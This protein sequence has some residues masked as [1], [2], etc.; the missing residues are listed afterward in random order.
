ME[1]SHRDIFLSNNLL[2]KGLFWTA[3]GQYTT[4]IEIAQKN[5]VGHFSMLR[6]EKRQDV[7][8]LCFTYIILLLASFMCRAELIK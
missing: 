8:K 1:E 4:D 3:E 6:L 7:I 5:D 2:N